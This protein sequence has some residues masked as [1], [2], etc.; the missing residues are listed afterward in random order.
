MTAAVILA[1]ALLLTVWKSSRLRIPAAIAS[2]FILCMMSI[3]CF[4]AVVI[5]LLT[6]NVDGN[7]SADDMETW[8][9]TSRK[10]SH[11]V[12][13]Y[14]SSNVSKIEDVAT[15]M[16]QGGTYEQTQ[17][18]HGSGGY[19]GKDFAGY[20]GQKLYSPLPGLGTVVFSGLEDYQVT[21]EFGTKWP[22]NTKIII[23]GDAGTI[24][25]LHGDYIVTPGTMVIGG[26]T[27]IGTSASNGWSTGCHEHLVWTP[28]PNWVETN[29][30]LNDIPVTGKSN[31]VNRLG[32]SQERVTGKINAYTQAQTEKI[33]SINKDNLPANINDFDMLIGVQDCGRV[34][35]TATVQAN[36]SLYSALVFNCGVAQLD[37]PYS[38]EI[39][40][41]AAR[42]GLDP[43]L[44][45]A[46]VK[47]ESNFDPNAVSRSGAQGL[48]QLMPPTAAWCGVTDSFNVEQNL[49]CAAWLMARLITLFPTLDLA[50][51]AY[52]AGE[53]TVGNC[54]CVPQNGETNIYVPR[55][56]GA[57][58]EYQNQ[59]NS[60][61]IDNGAWQQEN[62]LLGQIAVVIFD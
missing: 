55:V 18:F 2:G 58:Q 48:G 32:K 59:G 23:E 36:A 9:D 6:G 37:V 27:I 38:N 4:S 5:A 8:G 31:V 15:I 25:L 10:P 19:R 46:I 60:I 11:V 33:L 56:L 20:C 39:Q 41:A 29:I 61:L 53:G 44:L 45:A 13:K 14:N 34:G 51:A 26:E 62:T 57:Y 24:M 52:N 7:L 1:L 50:I 54:G 30:A 21:D 3:V 22:K 12:N 49:D 28:N 47:S 35:D 42:H 43:L 40:A 17:G 16:Y